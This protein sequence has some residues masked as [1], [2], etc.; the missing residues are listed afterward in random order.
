M[1]MVDLRPTSTGTGQPSLVVVSSE[2][3]EVLRFMGVLIDEGD[4]S[5]YDVGADRIARLRSRLPARTLETVREVDVDPKAYFLLSLLGADLPAP[6]GIDELL[7]AIAEDRTLTWRYVLG[8]RVAGINAEDADAA[9]LGERIALGDEA[10]IETV[11]RW[12]EAC[13]AP[14]RSVLELDP[15]VH[16]ERVTAAVTAVRPLWEEVAGEAMGAIERDVAHRCT[17]LEQG[18]PVA[19]IVVEATN[20]YALPTDIPLSEVVLMPTYWLRPWIVVARRRGVELLTS[21][22]ADEFVSLPTEA[23]SPA[24][25]K[26]F[27]ALSDEGR[28]KLL[29]RM[30]SGPISLTEA[31]EELDVAKATAH[32]HL[33]TLRQAGLVVMRGEGRGKRYALRDDPPEVARDALANYVTPTHARGDSTATSS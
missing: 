13:P 28:L 10:A 18:A 30:S 20:G 32:H 5:G 22:V 4:G 16:G 7:A 31:G 12:D 19:D 9:V 15:E 29:R 6:H 21:V 3:A 27:K 11:E 24:L 2:A 25:L 14:V 1:R 17:Q 26:L 33:S 23:P 8:H